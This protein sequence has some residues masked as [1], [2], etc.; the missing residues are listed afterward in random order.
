MLASAGHPSRVC[1]S[2]GSARNWS[3]APRPTTRTTPRAYG[4]SYPCAC[5]AGIGRLAG[6]HVCRHA[7][8]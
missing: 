7:A 3:S 6:A 2:R 4:P 1:T 5:R 8:A